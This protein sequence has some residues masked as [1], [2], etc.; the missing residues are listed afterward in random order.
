MSD[1]ISGNC[2]C[3]H[4]KFEITASKANVV[5]CHCNKC[6]KMNGS[7]FSTFFV[8]SEKVFSIIE[9]SEY[10]SSYSTSEDAV[11]NFCKNCG[12]PIFNQTLKYPNLRMVHLGALNVLDEI[13]PNVNIFNQSKLSWVSFN[14]EIPSFEKEIEK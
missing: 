3:G 5:N 2:C 1:N 8:V 7:S 14:C 12:S 9:G 10:L 11:K 4:V 6:R 13:K